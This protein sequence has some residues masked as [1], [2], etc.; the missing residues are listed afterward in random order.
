MSR[1]FLE[2]NQLQSHPTVDELL[3]TWQGLKQQNKSA[4]VEDLC[5]DD[6]KKSAELR[7]HLRAVAAMMSILGIEPEAGL[8]GS[9]STEISLQGGSCRTIE[10][11]PSG[12]DVLATDPANSLRIPGYEV[13][14]ELGR[15]GMGVV[16]RARQQSLDRIVAL[17]MILAASHAGSTA[18]A[19]FLHEAKTIA[20]LKH[21]HVVQVYEFGT[22]EG[23]PYFSLEYLEGGS[24]ADK[25]RGEPQP[26]AQA[27]QTVQSL[28][29]AVQAAHE[30]GIVH[31]DLKPANV[32]L[33]SDGTPKITD[34]GVAKQGDSA[35]T[36]TGDVLGTP[37]YMAPEQAEG[38]TTLVGPAADIY[39]LG[40]IL[41]ELLTGRP[42]FKGASAWETIQLVTKSEPV[43][44]CQLQ[45]GVPRDLETICLKCLEK[46][47]AKRYATAAELADDLRRYQAGEP[48]L[49]RP[50]GRF[51]RTWCWCLRNKM[52]AS[53][54][55]GFMLALM[56]GTAI[57]SWEAIRASR[58]E[59]FTRAALERARGAEAET[60]HELS[61]AVAAEQTARTEAD[62]SRSI[63]DFLAGDL[64]RQAEPALNSAEDHVSLLTVLDRAAGK[65]GDR[66][67]G[68]PEVEDTLRRT[69]GTTYHGLGS[70]E[71]A[72]RQ[73]R[74]VLE[75]SRR[76]HG[77]DSREALTA[78]VEL[79]H[80]LRHRG[81]DDAEVLEMAR[82]GSRGL[83]RILGPDHPDAIH[84]RMDLA[85]AFIDAGHSREAIALLEP[86][87]ARLESA[88]GLNHPDT[89]TS[90]IDLGR[91]YLAAGRTQESV[92]VLEATL[93]RL[94]ATAGI[95]HPDTLV[96]RH[97]LARAYSAAGHSDRAIAMFES[98]LRASESRL[99]LDHPGTL[100]TRSDLALAYSVAGRTSEA[101]ALNEANLKI[102]E[103]T[104]GADHPNTLAC[105]CNLASDFNAAGR[106]ELAINLYKSTLKRMEP[107]L[108][109]DHPKTLTCRANLAEAYVQAA[110][111]AEAV[112][113]FETTLKQME[114]T[115]GLD[116]P[117]T[118]TCRENLADAYLR[119][120]R[121]L[122]GIKQ[123]EETLAL[124]EAALGPDHPATNHSRNNLAVAYWQNGQ[125][126]RSVPLFEKLL[127]RYQEKLGR[128]H[129]R[130][131][132]AQ[133][134]LG[135]NYRDA[136]R[137][138]EGARLI[139]DMIS[140]TA[141]PS[142]ERAKLAWTPSLALAYEAA[143]EVAKAE[144]LRRQA[145]ERSRNHYGPKHLLTAR[146]LALLV[147]NLL[148]QR[149]WVEAED[150]LREAVAIRAADNRDDWYTFQYRSQLG[151]SLVG[152]RKYADAEPLLVQG[153]EGM[154]ARV[155]RALQSRAAPGR[156]GRR[157]RHR[158][159]HGLGQDRQGRPMASQAVEL[160]RGF[161]AQAMRPEPVGHRQGRD[162]YRQSRR[163]SCGRKV[164]LKAALNEEHCRCN[165]PGRIND[166]AGLH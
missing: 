154:K 166:V 108:G 129:P 160:F 67:A 53:L 47:P 124:K 13:L 15:G 79:A 106:S 98:I 34:F 105:C 155:Q 51:E 118:L 31:R 76:G 66:F 7:E 57:S 80:I 88:L 85:Q 56:L 90:R 4:T 115:L 138:A 75:E 95:D 37:S 103:A 30:R 89:L 113:L 1:S 78:L 104:L 16:Y 137:P 145:L 18:T 9:V 44:P 86:A 74:A 11:E 125:L 122:Q 101:I 41:Y 8:T 157:A 132:E 141:G 84:G 26:P 24:L 149:K 45:P 39:A 68:R 71:K 65:I 162:S 112:V 148:N 83:D 73:W 130:S 33:A 36:A 20:L 81:R 55:A 59:G 82:S 58:Q 94:Q 28:A 27:A 14:E 161:Q 143:G 158:A 43:S 70:W 119:V 21:P 109:S 150:V 2:T 139:E 163:G 123:H 62:K 49:A 134:N 69:I 142:A 133:A 25:L 110:R 121:T 111:P 87:A 131:L 99:G 91:A 97:E 135:V 10:G 120:G 117:T 19:R 128:D 12:L 40:A 3:R 147:E 46:A 50:I 126:D 165:E 156:T 29:L 164:G 35:I 23:K 48:I 32:L 146:A 92:N 5:S 140:R 63:S 61:R 60:R 38:K 159:L 17:K 93:E 54:A 114:S 100:A 22:H 102:Y 77:P 144:P 116:H 153:Y 127:S 52:V 64:L 152:Q 42:P 96:C 151:A 6:P 136:G 72:E 107:K